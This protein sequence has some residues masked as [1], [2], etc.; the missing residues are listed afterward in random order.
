VS[1]PATAHP[2]DILERVLEFLRTGLTRIAHDVRPID[3]G[4]VI[5]A[6][7]LAAVWAVNQLRVTQPLGFDELVALADRELAGTGYRHIAI[8]DQASGSRLEPAFRGAGWK[9]ERDLLMI[10][11]DRPDRDADTSVVVDA[12][13]DEVMA[14]MERWHLGDAGPR[15]DRTEIAQ[16]VDYNRLEARALG[17]RLLG[18][19]S[20]DGQLASIG[21]LRSDGTIGQVE[22]VYTVPEARGH[23][24]ARAV[25]T[26]AT[27]LARVAGNELIFI[28]ADDLDWP[29]LLYRKVGFRPAGHIW[30][31]HRP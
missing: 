7:A 29:K 26:R 2:P 3:A 31:F 13:E 4:L 16:L 22:D 24:Y 5:T 11:A 28:T 8:E 23:G 6:P 20:R 19:R 12:T 27:E 9:V 14:L 25:V 18:V 10:L 1:E 30:Q 21:Q 17:A 15:P